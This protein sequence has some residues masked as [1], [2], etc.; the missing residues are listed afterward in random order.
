V[1]LDGPF[2]LDLRRDGPHGLIAGTT[3]SGKTELLQT[4]IASLAYANRP[5]E[6]NFVLVDYKGDSAF[7]DC[8]NL[9]HTVGKVND[10]DPHL[11][12]RALE[13][14]AAELRYRE[15]FLADAAVKDIEDYQLLL[16]KEPHRPPLPRLLLVIDEFAS[17]I[18][19]LPD[20]VTGLV[21]IAQR[22]RSLGIHLLLATQRPSGVV[23][24]E[25]RANTNLR[26]SL[27]VTDASDS[28]DILN[29]SDAARIPKSAP[30]RGYARLGAG[31]LLSFQA[32]RVGGRRPGAVDPQ[33]RP[34]FVA[35]VGWRQLGY[36]APQVPQVER[37]EDVADTDLAAIVSA[38]R[39][40]AIAEG[41][42]EQRSPWLPPLE[43]QL[44]AST[45]MARHDATAAVEGEVPALPF[46]LSDVP[47]LQQRVVATFDLDRD[48]HLYFVGSSKSGRSQALRTLAGSVARL[49][50]PSQVHLYGIDCG[51][52]ALNPMVALPHCG[53]VV[54]R[55]EPERAARLLTRVA[56]EVN[57]RQRRLAAKGYADIREQRGSDADPMPHIVVM[58]DRWEGFVPTLGEIDPLPDLIL[59]MLREG[60]SVGVHLIITGDR[61]LATNSRLSTATE[62]K[63]A[64]KLADKTDVSLLGLS[65]KQLPDHIPPGRC[66]GPGAVETQ[67]MLLD[68]ETSGQGQAAALEELA[69]QAH[70]R[71]PEGAARPFR[72]DVLP[73]RISY[74]EAMGYRPA[75][76]RTPFLLLGVGGDELTAYSP[77]LSRSTSFIVAGPGR[78]GRS[79]VLAGAVRSLAA[80][81]GRVVIV[82]PRP[83]P[84]RD[85]GDLPGVVAVFADGSTSS[86]QLAELAE[87]GPEPLFVVI[88]DAEGLRE[89]DA[90]DFYLEVTKGQRPGT[91]LLIGG[92]ADGVGVGL[93]GWQVEAKKGRQGLL[94]SPQ[95][96]SDGDLVG[97]RVPRSILG[98]PVQPGRGWLH[99]GDGELTQIATVAE[100]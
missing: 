14:L 36:Q 44:T 49:T 41:I 17:M 52:G 48:G 8:V 9:P 86:A 53:A 100:N 22:G 34:P 50:D 73:T 72:V 75:D 87:D 66:F 88:D 35:R 42:A 97:T 40:A 79:T 31:N 1:G 70:Q 16:T 25:I 12:E 54:S 77:D 15:H 28:T 45:V 85:L 29:A 55:T 82:A 5:D 71:V 47:A 81:G 3:G 74:T 94:L 10:L 68:G 69:R 99:L 65:A 19:E 59:K 39:E 80:T 78:S 6:L 7:K 96:L 13:S 56:D 30:G 91:F 27:R 67:V 84:L 64:M 95:G 76:A 26:I 57:A 4:M 63:Y 37:R 93:S 11:V 38:I 90:K 20:F 32:G 51:S 24:P 62:N 46:G 60:P 2:S 98:Q 33:A 43:E 83:S 89:C 61:T 58:I 23:S 21:S 92:N 18:K